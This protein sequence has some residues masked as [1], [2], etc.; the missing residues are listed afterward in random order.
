MRTDERV[1]KKINNVAKLLFLF[2]ED[3]TVHA[4]HVI[5]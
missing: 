4:Y 3:P 1:C 2:E 5:H